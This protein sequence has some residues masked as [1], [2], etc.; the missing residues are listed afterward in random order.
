MSLSFRPA[1][2]VSSLSQTDT[3]LFFIRHPISSLS[4]VWSLTQQ[5]LFCDGSNWSKDG[6]HSLSV[7]ELKKQ[8]VSNEWVCFLRHKEQY[9][10]KAI[11][12]SNEGRLCMYA[13][14]GEACSFCF[15]WIALFG[16]LQGSWEYLAPLFGTSLSV[17]ARVALRH[18]FISLHGLICLRGGKV[19]ICG[20]ARILLQCVRWVCWTGAEW[21]SSRVQTL[22]YD[23]LL[24]FPHCAV[25]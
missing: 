24:G 4:G 10:T 7:S 5:P 22:P 23:V 6:P 17:E 14:A 18:I 21:E 9:E 20:L 12:N 2:S 25:V 8:F 11:S 19:P 1:W 16:L 15:L 13:R 3:L